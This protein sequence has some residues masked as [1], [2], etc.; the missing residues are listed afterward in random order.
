MA[1]PVALFGIFMF[2]LSQKWIPE[3]NFVPL[4]SVSG[5][6][7]LLRAIQD[8]QIMLENQFL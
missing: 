1:W 4:E 8:L 6:Y 3:S 2:L 7:N 5:T